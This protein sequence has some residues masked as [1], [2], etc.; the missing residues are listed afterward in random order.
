ME[1]SDNS[2]TLTFGSDISMLG[3][4]KLATG[5]LTLAAYNV[6][7]SGKIIKGNGTFNMSSS[8]TLTYLTGSTLE[9]QSGTATIGNEYP[10]SDSPENLIIQTSSTSNVITLDGNRTVQGTL[11]LNQGTLATGSNTLTVNT[12]VVR[13]EGSFNGNI[14]YGTNATLY[15]FGVSKTIGDE[16]TAVSYPKNFY[17][18]LT[19]STDILT[20]NANRSVDGTLTLKN[21]LLKVN[22]GYAF[23]L[24][25]S[26]SNLGTLDRDGTNTTGKIIGTFNRWIAA[27]NSSLILYPMATPETPYDYRSAR[28][29]FN[30]VLTSGPVQVTFVKGD[31]GGNTSY[32]PYESGAQTKKYETYWANGYWKIE[33]GTS[34]EFVLGSGNYSV[35]LYTAGISG[36]SAL[37]KVRVLKKNSLGDQWPEVIIGTHANGSD[38]EAK[39][40]GYTS[41]SIFGLGG[42]ATEDF[43][44]LQGSNPVTL[45][46]FSF[47]TSGNDANLTW[48]TSME[49]NNS[50]FDIERKKVDGEWSK[51]GYI[52]GNGNS[53]SQIT[54][55]YSDK[56]LVTGKY[57]YRLKQI[58][59][60]GNFEYHALKGFVEIGV[61]NKFELSQNYPNP[62]NPVT[63][64]DFE[65]P[66]NGMVSIK[67]YDML[68]KEVK[69]LVNEIKQAGYHTLEVNAGNLSSGTYF[70]RMNAGKFV[71]TLKM[72]V[73]K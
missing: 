51:I 72:V 36:I 20:I 47:S 14:S 61:P 17:L 33:E 28:L 7:V 56:N 26:E 2:Y 58:D 62:F 15:Y 23:T 50:G 70:Y 24:G 31:P 18:Y 60:N 21:G 29:S 45:A 5:V 25:S 27:G 16:I 57:Q 53:N 13:Q 63:K 3:N 40:T 49:E 19:N 64:I 37:D 39:R 66:E 9:Y 41:F 68:G 8:G 10:S 55:K 43:N 22:D 65:V 6:T 34:G 73:V 35:N 42:N 67:I 32:A 38:N 59:F 54:Y 30:D 11:T 52:K 46:S 69:T 1:L 4:L 44:N 71:K 48:V 12:S